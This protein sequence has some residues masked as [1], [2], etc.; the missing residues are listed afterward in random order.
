MA[1]KRIQPRL[2]RGREVP[3]RRCAR[4]QYRREH[5]VLDALPDNRPRLQIFA[6]PIEAGKLKL[7]TQVRAE[8]FCVP[9]KH[10]L[11]PQR[12]EEKA[13]S[14]LAF[15]HSIQYRALLYLSCVTVYK[16]R[17]VS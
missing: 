1:L 12:I 7:S 16:T 14:S 11:S 9:L 15:P 5:T 4:L 10:A 6:E 13:G 3:P 17:K 8:A 2:P